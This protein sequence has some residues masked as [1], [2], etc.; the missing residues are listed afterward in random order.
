MIDEHHILTGETIR[1]LLYRRDVAVA[2]HR[3][4]LA[5][6]LGITDIEMQ[7]LVH[8]SERGALTPADLASLLRLSSGGAT[9]LVQR[10]ERSGHVTR[11]AHPTDGRSILVQLSRRAAE[12]LDAAQAPV[13]SGM[14]S[15]TR[16]LTQT[17]RITVTD[18]LTQLAVLTEALEAAVRRDADAPKNALAR[19]VPSLWG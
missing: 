12:R 9:A 8:I 11:R 14:D 1:R 18:V 19:P 16:S 5:R 15:V 17:E 6:S 2:R 4:T 3:S 13:T 7:A 10:L